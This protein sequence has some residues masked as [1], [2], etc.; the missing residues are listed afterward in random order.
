MSEFQRSFQRALTIVERQF[1]SVDGS[2][3]IR[4]PPRQLFR[5]QHQTKK[6]RCFA[7][8]RTVAERAL[9]INLA[10]QLCERPPPNHPRLPIGVRAAVSDAF[11]Y[12]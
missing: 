9:Q 6:K 11:A 12:T 1:R 2:P 3:T 8:E 4:F 10:T 7:P 5:T